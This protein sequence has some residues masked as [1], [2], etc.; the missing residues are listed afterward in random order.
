MLFP[1][2][3]PRGRDGGLTAGPV[4]PPPGTAGRRTTGGR[5]S[6]RPAPARPPAPR[7]RRAP[8][9]TP[10][11]RLRRAD[12]RRRRRRPTAPASRRTARSYHFFGPE[13]LRPVGR[14]AG[15]RPI[16]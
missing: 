4:R 5:R 2:G 1:R 10:P 11:R 13:A 3:N 16:D 7:P 14:I 6:R 9:P 15:G 8:A 12:P